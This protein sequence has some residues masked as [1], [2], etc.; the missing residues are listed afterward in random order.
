MASATVFHFIHGACFSFTFED[1]KL[2]G[3]PSAEPLG[4]LLVSTLG[5]SAGKKKIELGKGREQWANKQKI[6][7]IIK[8]HTKSWQRGDICKRRQ[9]EEY[10]RV[11]IA[12]FD[13]ILHSA[14]KKKKP[15]GASWWV[16]GLGWLPRK[17]QHPFLIWM[18]TWELCFIPL[19][20]LTFLSSLQ[21]KK[22]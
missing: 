19:S 20:L 5:F 15:R 7:L 11:T 9:S 10:M 21:K 2:W 4:V 16:G 22:P 18:G 3:D 12:R 8:E 13:L 14:I 6:I 17:L 1:P